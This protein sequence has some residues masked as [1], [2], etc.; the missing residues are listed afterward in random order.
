MKFQFQ[1][2][3]LNKLDTFLAFWI[4]ILKCMREWGVEVEDIVS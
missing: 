3:V 1:F 4:P 2:T